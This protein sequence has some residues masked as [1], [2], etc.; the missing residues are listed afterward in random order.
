MKIDGIVYN[1]SMGFVSSM[2]VRGCQMHV[3]ACIMKEY[4]LPFI[5]KAGRD[6]NAAP[7]QNAYALSYYA[8]KFLPFLEALNLLSVVRD[9]NNYDT[10]PKCCR[11]TL[12]KMC[13]SRWGSAERECSAIC[14]WMNAPAEDELI[15]LV[16]N[17][18]GGADSDEWL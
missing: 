4:L 3:L 5:M 6:N 7:S 10:L 12:K 2:R 1:Y 11:N 9:I 14:E 18:H 13:A 17:Y 8:E 16:S 15:A